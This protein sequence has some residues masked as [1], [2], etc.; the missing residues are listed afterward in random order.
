MP[1]YKKIKE[2]E[3]SDGQDASKVSSSFIPTFRNETKE[4]TCHGDSLIKNPCEPKPQVDSSTTQEHIVTN[5]TPSTHSIELYG[6]ENDQNVASETEETISLA[7]PLKNLDPEERGTRFVSIVITVLYFCIYIQLFIRIRDR[8]VMNYST[9][10]PFFPGV[11]DTEAC[12]EIFQL[13]RDMQDMRLRKKKRQSI[14]PL[15]GRI[16]LAKSSGVSRISLRDA[17]GH[18]CP[19]GYCPE[20]VRFKTIC[21]AMVFR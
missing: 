3:T 14:R 17:V 5:L 1:P 16:Y 12:Q 13:A 18:K 9:N 19:V 11:F 20:V 6:G 10:T 15:P 2:P 7:I 21:I 4:D 8:F